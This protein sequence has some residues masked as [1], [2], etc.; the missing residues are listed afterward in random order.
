MR[1]AIIDDYQGVALECAD[2]SRVQAGHEIQVFRKPFASEEELV[3]TLSGFEVICVMRE[4]TGFPK[5]VIDRLHG[6]K[7]IATPGMA[8]AAIDMQAA[9][10]RG[11]VVSGGTSPGHCTSELT[12]ALLIAIARQLHVQHESVR[13]G[14]WQVGLGGELRGKTLGIIGLGR[15]G[16]QVAGYAK[17]F[18]MNLIAW[19]QNMTGERAAACGARLVTKDELFRQSDYI[20]IHLKLSAR[21]TDLVTTRELGLMKPTAYI[22][23]TSR[24]PIINESALLQALHSGTIAGAGL[25]VFDVEPLPVDHPMRTAP[26]VLL[27]PHVGY[28]TRDNYRIFYGGIVESLEA[29][30]GGKPIRIVN[31]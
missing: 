4:R 20:T 12:F 16:E 29:W 6:L 11:I 27:T 26:R 10:D 31:A 17:A 3:A 2:W 19:S 23:N 28:V 9:K 15:L 22:I 18:N 13:K 8:N 24:G 5:Q 25:D 30:L 21:T 14:G 7:F 1:I